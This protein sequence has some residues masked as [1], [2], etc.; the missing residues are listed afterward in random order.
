MPTGP[1]APEKPQELPE[2]KKPA[3]LE[4]FFKKIQELDPDKIL[5]EYESELEEFQKEFEKMQTD[6]E[7]RA[8]EIFEQKWQDYVR[9]AFER[10]QDDWSVF[11]PE[12][13]QFSK[14][15][16]EITDSFSELC[17]KGFDNINRRREAVK[18]AGEKHRQETVSGQLK[19]EYEQERGALSVSDRERHR[20]IHET[21]S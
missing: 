6:I 2:Q 3:D 17:E 16:Q 20:Q 1:R 9:Q 13:F 21:Q 15:Y 18:Q 11:S 4:F 14:I 19:T 5:L 10:V 7:S 12:D 8:T